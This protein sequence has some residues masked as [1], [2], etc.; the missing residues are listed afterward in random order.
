MDALDAG[1]VSPAAGEAEGARG[2][3]DVAMPA[4]GKSLPSLPS[5]LV[6]SD[7][8]IDRTSYVDSTHV[9]GDA[10]SLK[11]GDLLRMSKRNRHRLTHA[12]A[13]VSWPVS[14]RRYVPGKGTCLGAT[15]DVSGPRL[16]RYTAEHA[17][18]IRLIN[19]VIRTTLGGKPFR[20][21][22]LQINV[23]T[24]SKEHVDKGNL[25]PSILF[26][27]GNYN[28]GVFRMTDGSATLTPE[29]KGSFLVIDGTRPHSSEPFT[30]CR[31]SVVA[32][33]H[34]STPGLP[35]KDFQFLR[36]LGFCLELPSASTA[37]VAIDGP[38]PDTQVI[39]E[40]CN[41][42]MIEFCCGDDSLMGSAAASGPECHV[43]RV[44]RRNDVTTK[45]GSAFVDKAL[46]LAQNTVGKNVL[47][48]ASIP[49]TGGTSW[50]HINALK[51]DQTRLKIAARRREFRRI[52]ASFVKSVAPALSAGVL[53]AIEWPQGCV[54]WQDKRARGFLRQHHLV[55]TNFHGCMYGLC[56]T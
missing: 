16:G 23:N 24:E 5:A 6:G 2:S 41:R 27:L 25:G 43:I 3:S 13:A 33:F 9:D 30:G 54:Y 34:A 31:M 4:G 46:A 49:C 42:V 8:A 19:G 18:L 48:W 20:W 38:E 15:F 44:T 7:A 17:D 36:E 10:I 29:Q 52:W 51:G 22:S 40:V 47:V 50:T 45:P 12:L 28:G 32:F 1:C 14:N 56:P 26:T 55:R 21:G 35:S 53:V 37:L 39:P 11:H